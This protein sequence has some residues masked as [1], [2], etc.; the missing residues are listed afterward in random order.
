M[1][2]PGNG[3][4]VFDG[5]NAMDKNYLTEVMGLI[6]KLS[7]NDTSKIGRLTNASKE[8]SI[9]FADKCIQFSMINKY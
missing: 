5:I 3:N 8:F 6:G 1:Y 2:A 9:I 7:S 4:N